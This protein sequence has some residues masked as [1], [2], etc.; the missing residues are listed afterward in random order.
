MC[1]YGPTSVTLAP[2][3]PSIGM[4]DNTYSFIISLGEVNPWACFANV[5]SKR[6]AGTHC[7]CGLSARWSH[8]M[9]SWV[10]IGDWPLS[11]WWI[12][13]RVL[14]STFSLNLWLT[15]KIRPRTLAPSSST[16]SPYYMH[17][18]TQV[19]RT[20]ISAV[21]FITPFSGSH[22]Y[23]KS[24]C[25]LVTLLTRKCPIG[26][27][28]FVHTFFYENLCDTLVWICFKFIFFKYVNQCLRNRIKYYAIPKPP[29]YWII[30]YWKKPLMIRIIYC[31]ALY[32]TKN[33]YM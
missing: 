21:L 5:P 18:V 6:H 12:E 25:G 7:V 30:I 1:G 28:H 14:I 15:C 3:Q 23:P 29:S 26:L 13:N 20:L 24:Q 10:K 4:I 31:L 16:N 27:L 9:A 11:H 17:Y 8:I 32:H 33:K 22:A 2:H 19:G